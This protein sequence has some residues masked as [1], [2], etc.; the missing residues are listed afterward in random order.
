MVKIIENMSNADYHASKALSKSGLDEIH[1]SPLHY[2]R[3]YLDPDRQSRKATEAMIIGS[4]FHTLVLEPQKFEDE[5]TV[6][7]VIDKRT[8]AGKADYAAW[9]EQAGDKQVLDQ[10]DYNLLKKMASAIEQHKLASSYLDG[11]GK[12]E[13]SIF[14]DMGGVPMRCRPDYIRTD[15]VIVDIKTSTTASASGFR[16]KAYD[17]RYH[18]Q[19]ALYA[20]GYRRAYGEDPK[21]FVFVVAEKQDPYLVSV[22]ETSTEDYA[23]G[24]TELMEDLATY[25]DCLKAN[26]WPGYNDDQAIKGICPEWVLNKMQREAA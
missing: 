20:E 18:V 3:R 10:A 19:A 4:A 23:A 7:P 1:K 15:G 22:F 11:F 9:L 25:K 17:M 13:L 24:Y 16:K 12:A 14:F 5:Y 26:H 6:M 8:N 21:G 2:W